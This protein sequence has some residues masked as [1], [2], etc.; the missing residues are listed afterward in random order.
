MGRGRGW[1]IGIV[2]VALAGSAL[3]SGLWAQAKPAQVTIG[4][5]VI[6]NAE[7]IGK[8]LGWFEK[9]MGV[10]INWKQ[11]DSGRDVNAA[12]ASGSVDMG[13]VGTSPAAAGISQGVPYE[14]IWIHDL[15]GEN[16]SLVAKKGTGIKAVADLLGKK[17]GTPFGAATHYSL[18]GAL[19][20]FKVDPEKVT[21]I[22]MQPL[23][24][25]AAW[26]RGDLDAG[27]VREPTLKKIVDADGEIVLTSR[28]MAEKGYLTGDVA[29]VRKAFAEKY[30]DVVVKYLRVQ[31]K[32]VDLWMKSPKEAA[33]AVAKEFNISP[34]EAERE[35]RTLVWVG[36]R[37]QL[38]GAYLGTSAK[39]G[40]FAKV[41]KDTADFLVSQKTIK[42]APS[43]ASFEKAITPAYLAKALKQGEDHDVGWAAR[44]RD[45]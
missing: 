38:S 42:S 3:V 24:M 14:V 43:E 8:Q 6:P 40:K 41:L 26:Q 36:G 45:R 35:M 18:L 4:Y 37:E 29:V 44:P 10:K 39:R 13:L 31:A 12:I 5:Q 19:K 22:D 27:Y 16:E 11:F 17:V 33:G 30:P 32:G 28:T 1:L 20:I 21:M 15:E 34:E 23:D 25:L 2:T 7:I 9:E